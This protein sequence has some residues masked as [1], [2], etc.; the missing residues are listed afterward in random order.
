MLHASS[1]AKASLPKLAALVLSLLSVAAEPAP[2]REKASSFQ[3]P[4][5]E[6]GARSP[7]RRYAGLTPRACRAELARQ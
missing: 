1:A 3:E 5:L 4:L 7:A 6:L 2:S